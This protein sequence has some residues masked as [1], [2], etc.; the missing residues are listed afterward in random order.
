MALSI[1][2]VC[3]RRKLNFLYIKNRDVIFPSFNS[4][5][6]LRGSRIG[7]ELDKTEAK[8]QQ[9]LKNLKERTQ[10][11]TLNTAEIPE[12]I[13]K[14][15]IEK[16]N[17][18][19]PVK[20]EDAPLDDVQRRLEAK[21]TPLKRLTYVRQLER[22]YNKSLSLLRMFGEK[23][24]TLKMP[25][26]LG[27]DKLPCP[28]ELMLPS[29]LI[30]AY[31]N[32]DEFSIGVG[33][34]GNPKT[35]GFFLEKQLDDVKFV[36]VS[37]E[38]VVIIK[39]SHKE[40]LKDFQD[41]ISHSSLSA[42]LT[43]DDGGHWKSVLVRS[44]RAGDLM[45]IIIM[46]PQTLTK[47]ELDLEKESLRKYFET[48]EKNYNLKSLYFQACSLSKCS[49]DQAPFQL[50]YGDSSIT[51][52]LNAM[53]FQISPESY[54]QSNTQAA[55]SLYESVKKLCRVNESTT[56]ID[57]FSGTGP[58]SLT[59]AP[60]VKKC[61]G[62]EPCVQAYND[63]KNNAVINNHHNVEF[64]HG[65]PDNL[66]REVLYQDYY[67][68]LIVIINPSR[69]ELSKAALRSLRECKYLKKIIF[70]SNKPRSAVDNFIKLC[71]PSGADSYIGKY[72]V[73]LLAVPY[74]ISPQTE[75]FGLI[76]MFQRL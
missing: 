58:V 16:E 26:A 48:V 11:T 57:I 13:L 66:L 19:A 21:I 53:R 42:N 25:I 71:K 31:R 41:Y 54:F 17:I 29:P 64:I 60:H 61:I 76:V 6:N 62:I 33:P 69:V 9:L 35:V 5:R 51:E 4:V 74:D 63:A 72:F 15:V 43:L 3:L 59:F 49:H 20:V 44:N 7:R 67:N 24:R 65:S 70:I 2:R 32:Q 37:P 14:P 50:L 45:G 47:K 75:H 28:V 23:L 52:E 18:E 38:E 10:K 55:E 68:D 27:S 39:E 36:C 73:P 22:K 34:D 40:F 56:V 12:S 30:E 8:F 1:R 46:N